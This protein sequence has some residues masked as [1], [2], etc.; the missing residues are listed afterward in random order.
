MQAL[1]GISRSISRAL[2]QGV[3]QRSQSS[4]EAG[5]KSGAGAEEAEYKLLTAVSGFPKPGSNYNID[6]ILKGQIGDDAYFVARHVDDWGDDRE[7]DAVRE[8]LSPGPEQVPGAGQGRAGQHGQGNADV[9]GVADGVGGWRA[10]GVDPGQF[11]VNLMANCERLVM[12]G[13]FLSNQPSKLL[14]QG[15]REMQENKLPI[16]G[17]ST[18]CLMMLSHSD[19]K[20]YTSNIGDSGFLVVR[21]GEVVHRSQEQQHY[22][23]TP[24]QL[25]LPPTELQSEVLSDLPEQ[26]D[27]YEFSVEDGDVI[28]VAT[29]GIFDNVPDRLLVEEMDKVW[30]CKD[31]KRLQQCAN[32][33]ALMARRLSRDP[34]FL[35]PFSVNALAAGLEAEGGKPDDITVLLATV[36]L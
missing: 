10:Y 13:Y 23:N 21:G 18:A 9:I 2:V 5:V 35:S 27:R 32:S 4:S 6:N 28:L 14:A 33:I 15:F 26:A 31:E 22:F 24:F 36:S 34:K 1:A 25:S 19:L 30:L 29:D 7:G 17:S 12:A 8:R 20:L 3:V 16:I 11:S